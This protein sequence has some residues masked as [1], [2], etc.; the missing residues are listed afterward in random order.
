[1]SAISPDIIEV[2]HLAQNLARNRG[3]AVF[4]CRID[5][6]PACPHGFKDAAVDRDAIQKLW[7]DHPGPLIGVATGAASGIDVLDIDAKYETALAWWSAAAPRIPATTIFRTRSGGLHGY[8]LHAE[9]VGNTASKLA[10]G[11]DTR[12]DG[13]YVISWFAAGHECVDLSSPAPWPPWLL[14]CVLWEPSPSPPPRVSRKSQQQAGGAIEGVIRTISAAT[15]GERNSVLFW[16][17]CRLFERTR[18]GQLD[19]GEADALLIA[20][21][22]AAGLPEVEARQTIA[23]AWRR[24]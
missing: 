18:I 19:R 5:K 7:A 1:V 17:A 24:P 22:R 9:G 15:E 16:G 11:V 10:H 20:A 23:S 8:F 14:D 2:C 21:A 6:R 3:Y 12:R 4:P 13:G